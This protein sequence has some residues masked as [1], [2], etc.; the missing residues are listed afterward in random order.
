MRCLSAVLCACRISLVR[1]SN[2]YAHSCT[3]IWLTLS[4]NECVY[5]CSHPL[6]FQL[7]FA[8][9]NGLVPASGDVG[10]AALEVYLARKIAPGDAVVCPPLIRG[11]AESARHHCG[12]RGYHFLYSALK[13]FP[14]PS[15]LERA[16]IEP[17]WPD[18]IDPIQLELYR[19]LGVEVDEKSVYRRGR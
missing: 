6:V 8:L 7:Q 18:G 17:H 15:V 12:P 2:R 19:R 4:S 9:D 5:S 3:I 10:L 1:V 11:L 14:S 16:Q 13:M